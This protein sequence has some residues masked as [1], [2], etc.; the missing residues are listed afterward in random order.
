MNDIQL[1]RITEFHNAIKKQAVDLAEELGVDVQDIEKSINLP[2]QQKQK[3][4]QELWGGPQPRKS[5]VWSQLL[6]EVS[7]SGKDMKVTELS[8]AA[9]KVYTAMTDE[10]RAALQ[11]RADADWKERFESDKMK[12]KICKS[13]AAWT[14]SAKISGMHCVTLFYNEDE[15]SKLPTVLAST[16]AAVEVARDS[17][18]GEIFR[19]DMFKHQK[20]IKAQTILPQE[21]S[22]EFQSKLKVSRTRANRNSMVELPTFHES[23]KNGSFGDKHFQYIRQSLLKLYNEELA[24]L[25]QEPMQ[26]LPW[27]RIRKHMLHTSARDRLVPTHDSFPFHARHFEDITT[28]KAKYCK[29]IMDAVVRGKFR[30]EWKGS[31]YAERDTTTE[32]SFEEDATDGSEDLGVSDD[33]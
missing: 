21:L 6:R 12:K 4:T 26:Y 20:G 2:L 15:N 5:N 3:Q 27:A 16:P 31:D 1:K 18:L 25:G 30:F 23:W 8:S 22:S 17:M 28:M 32:S 29:H 14:A 10:E 11:E 13:M 19:V 33:E 7:K 9:K 24:K